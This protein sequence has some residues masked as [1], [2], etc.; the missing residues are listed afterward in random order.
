MV[1][2]T[3][4]TALLEQVLCS[5]PPATTTT[6]Q[7]D[8][9]VLGP[10]GSVDTRYRCRLGALVEVN[11]AIGAMCLVACDP[12]TLIVT[13]PAGSSKILYVELASVS[14]LQKKFF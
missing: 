9:V 2:S 13:N 8:Q 5:D 6:W 1:A 12:W 11:Q 14:N 10:G 3:G 4:D 7:W